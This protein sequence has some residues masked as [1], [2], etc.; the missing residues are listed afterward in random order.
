MGSYLGIGKLVEVGTLIVKVFRVYI[1]DRQWFFNR[2]GRRRLGR[3]R[4]GW[5]VKL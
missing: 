2:R 4:R 1:G 3:L 5:F